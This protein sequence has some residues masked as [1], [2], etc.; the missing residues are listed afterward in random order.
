MR[1]YNSR[2]VWTIKNNLS[3]IHAWNEYESSGGNARNSQ[4]RECPTVG[5]VFARIIIA[6]TR[7]NMHVGLCVQYLLRCLWLVA[8]P[9][10]ILAPSAA[11]AR[12]PKS[13]YLFPTQHP[14]H[15]QCMY[16]LTFTICLKMLLYFVCTVSM[17]RNHSSES[18]VLRFRVSHL[19]LCHLWII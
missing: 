9:L 1:T 4:T 18:V 17:V 3:F 10:T 15:S 5:N 14:C 19:I 2:S 13:I 12:W 6:R 8:V 16:H 7:V 11:R